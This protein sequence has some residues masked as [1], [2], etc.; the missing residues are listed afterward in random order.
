MTTRTHL[1]STRLAV[2][3]LALGSAQLGNLYREVPDADA[4]ETLN[5]AARL[6]INYVDTA[7]H[8]GLGLSERRLGRYLAGVNRSDVVVSTKVGRLIRPNPSFHGEADT[9][10]FAVPAE[11]L[12]VRDYSFD[13]TYRSLEESLERMGTDYVDVVF[14]HDPD[15]FEQEATEGALPALERMRSEGMISSFG[16][17]MNQ[18]AMLA[19]F[20]ERFDV[21]VV[22]VASKF[23]LLDQ[24]AVDDLLPIALRRGVS[25]VVAGVF[26]SG[27]L[28][29]NDPQPGSH[30]NYEQAPPAL[31]ARAQLLSG[32]ARENGFSLPQIAAQFPLVHPA[33]AVVCLGARSAAQCRRNAELFEH[34]VPREFYEDL[35]AA[36]LINPVAMTY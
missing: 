7:P 4:A 31:V 2:S 18:S 3:R 26:N 15:D 19:R 27:I 1:G 29:T 12:R 20:I 9:E 22:M 34:H 10:G 23:S 13:G 32:I 33:V 21:D 30:Y 24:A 8:Y 25:V 5:E 35:A 28:A 11:T 14:V 36:G 16:A 6:G 17:G